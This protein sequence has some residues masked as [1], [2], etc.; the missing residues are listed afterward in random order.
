MSFS[1]TVQGMG[2]VFSACARLREATLE[3][4]DQAEALNVLATNV[5]ILAS[6]TTLDRGVYFTL[7]R[8]IEDLARRITGTVGLMRACAENLAPRVLV[9]QE[10]ARQAGKVREG[11]ALLP[12]GPNRRH[13]SEALQTL[14]ATFGELA[15]HVARARHL[16]QDHFE[17]L[18]RLCR[19]L[20]AVAT[21]YRVEAARCDGERAI[22][23]G[24]QCD[25]LDA[26][27]VAL[28]EVARIGVR[29]TAA[30]DWN[31]DARLE[32]VR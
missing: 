27:S 26:G 28:R 29:L 2:A 30:L 17:A 23:V 22:R 6:R 16:L 3:L 32:V 21:K 1:P 15:V 31:A 19:R 13:V 9:G 4:D 8:E 11:L 25:T 20:A 14:E 18:E 10:R 24:G 7:A 12:A 5:G